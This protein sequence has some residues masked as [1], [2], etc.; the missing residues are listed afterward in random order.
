MRA[1]LT[2]VLLGMA[3]SCYSQLSNDELKKLR[4]KRFTN[5]VVTGSMVFLAGAADGC[6]QALMYQYAGFKR[7]FPN[8]NDQFW[9]PSMS[10]ANKYKNGDPRQGAKFPGSRTYL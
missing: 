1:I 6:N 7:V 5:Y 9:K 4:K 10:G 8:A 3:Y 2:I